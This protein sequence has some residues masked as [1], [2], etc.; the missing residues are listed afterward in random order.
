MDD[1]FWSDINLGFNSQDS[2]YTESMPIRIDDISGVVL[3]LL[4]GAQGIMPVLLPTDT[5]GSVI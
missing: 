4:V 1:L 5:P 3:E 2:G